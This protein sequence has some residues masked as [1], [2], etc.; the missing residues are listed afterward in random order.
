M[1]R[2]K[3]SVHAKIKGLIFDDAR[4]K[5]ATTQL[6]KIVESIELR[7][8]LGIGTISESEFEDIERVLAAIT[9]AVQCAWS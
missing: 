9:A 8:D 3:T 4:E 2:S 1:K 7:R 5:R 6:R